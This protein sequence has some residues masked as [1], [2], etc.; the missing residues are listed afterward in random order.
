MTT[1]NEGVCNWWSGNTAPIPSSFYHSIIYL[2]SYSALVS[3][4]MWNNEIIFQERSATYLKGSVRD[5][6]ITHHFHYLSR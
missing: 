3:K 5:I 2:F 4:T 6:F 1:A